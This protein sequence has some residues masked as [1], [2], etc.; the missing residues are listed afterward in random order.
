[1]GPKKGGKKNLPAYWF[2]LVDCEPLRGL[3]ASIGLF[4]RKLH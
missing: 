2:E 4:R 3:K 1:M